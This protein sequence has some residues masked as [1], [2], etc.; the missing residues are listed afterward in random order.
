[1]VPLYIKFGILIFMFYLNALT[2]DP[3]K[4]LRN[5]NEAIDS[6]DSAVHFC[7]FWCR[8]I[9]E[10]EQNESAYNMLHV[11]PALN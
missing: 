6:Q 11:K 8:G 4:L 7:V 2:S 1:M 10:K 3:R 5:N 9:V